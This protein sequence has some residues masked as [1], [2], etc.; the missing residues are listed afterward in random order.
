MDR[1]TFESILQQGESSTVE[2][3]RCGGTPSHDTLETI[4]SFANR[5]GGSIFLGVSAMGEVLGIP[6]GSTLEIERN[7]INCTYNPNLFNMPPSLEFEQIEF[8]G[9]IVLRVWVPPTQGVFR[10]KG[11]V[12]DRLADADVELKSDTQ[13]AALYLRKYAIFTEQHIFPH[14]RMEDLDSSLIDR[15]R[16]MAAGR[17]PGHPWTNMNDIELLRSA[18][19]YTRDI[20]TGAEGL[21]RAAALLLGK[22]EVVLAACP[23]YKTDAIYR[24]DQPDRYDDRETVRTNLI[25]SYDQLHAFCA[26][27]LPDPFYLEGSLRV[28]VR[29]IVVREVVSN[30]LIHREF[31]SPFPAKLIIDEVGLRTENASRALFEGRLTLSDFNPMPKNPIIANFFVQI[32]YAEELGSGLRN[33]EKYSKPFLGGDPVLDEGDIFRTLVPRKAKSIEAVSA[34]KAPKEQTRLSILALLE[35]RG[36]LSAVEAAT[37]VHVTSK[38]AAKYLKGLVEEGLAAPDGN[39]RTRRYYRTEIS[40]SN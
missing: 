27:H 31:T 14:L 36:S 6:S 2:F 3:K 34:A 18:Q 5:S 28:S 7:L 22:D 11:H 37:A 13:I 4:C 16:K 8:D 24:H 1:P 23:A 25:D 21:N 10:L 15:C 12:L 9:K 17:R 30:V 20:E 33:L 19:L 26:K 35:K 32:G 40:R 29:D 39:T 38:T